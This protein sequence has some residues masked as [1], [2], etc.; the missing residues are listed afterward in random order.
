MPSS[1]L[2]RFTVDY[3]HVLFFVKSQRYY[4]K[5]Q[6][7]PHQSFGAW[8]QNNKDGSPYDNNNPRLRPERNP[9]GRIKRAVWYIPTQPYPD[10]HFAVFP[11]ELI[12]TPIIAGCPEGGTVLDPFAGSGTTLL[13]AH[14][15]L[16]NWI[17]IELNPEYVALA[18]KRLTPYIQQQRLETFLCPP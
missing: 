1:I 2:D 15:L 3:E 11:E 6:Y 4:F 9:E 14:K 16:R 13:A 17:G 10:A 18:K 5:T 8:S 7:E 12:K